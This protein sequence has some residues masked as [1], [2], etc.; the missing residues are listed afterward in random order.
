MNSSR[1]AERLA[2]R[3]RSVTSRQSCTGQSLM[4]IDVF[5][6]GWEEYQKPLT[7]AGLNVVQ[8]NDF[9]ATAAL[10]RGAL[11]V[12]V[13]LF[14][15]LTPPRSGVL[16][17]AESGYELARLARATH[18]RCLTGQAIPSAALE[19]IDFTKPLPASMHFLLEDPFS[20]EDV[21]GLVARYGKLGEQPPAPETS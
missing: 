11:E 2:V 13:F 20:V 15:P 6:F 14:V 17:L 16:N 10:I 5:L 3:F 21:V 1:I 12:K 8:C 4:K 7:D 9:E 19:H 18:P